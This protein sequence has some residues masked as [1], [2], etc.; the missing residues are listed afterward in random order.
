MPSQSASKPSGDFDGKGFA[1]KLPTR[2]GVYLMRDEEGQALY[3]GKALNLRKRVGS[4]F[5]ARPKGERIMRMV[6]RIRQVE[7][8]ITRTEAEALLLEN[9]WIKSLKPRYNV[10]LRDDKS[11]PWIVLSTDHE[12]P[13]ISF[14]RGARDPKKR[15]FGP[16]PSAHSVRDSIN[17]IQ[18]LF[19]LRNCEDSYFAHRNRP[20]LQHQ[21]RR[22]TAPCVGL[23]NEADYAEQVND[24]VLF[25]CG[26][27]RK[28]TDRLVER[29]ESA[30][31]S[32]DFESAAVYR[33]QINLLQQM[34]A[35][36]FVSGKQ[37]DID[38]IAV[39]SEQG[40]FCVE[41]M[42][43]RGGRHLGQRNFF[44]SQTEGHDRSGVMEAFLGQYYQQRQSP[45]E[46][47]ISDPVETGALL[48][49]VFSEAAG[50]KVRIQPH[51][52]GDRR[53][54][55]EMTRTNARQALLLRLASQANMT[56]QFEDLRDLLG[57]EE[58]PATIECF[59]ISHTAGNETV[60]SC[61][62]FDQNGPVKSKYRRYNLRGITPGDDYAA[63][64]QV[65]S[66][67][68]ARI[69]AEEGSLPDLVLIDGGKG[70]LS[71]AED[72]MGEFGL[73][74]IPIVGIAKGQ[75][76]RAGH[77]QWIT[78]SPHRS[79]FPGPQS[80]ASHLVQQVR[81]E[82]HRFAITG[83]RGRRQKAV[84]KSGLEKI[85]GI[86]PG[87]RRALLNHFG[88]LQGVKQAGIEELSSV[89]GISKVLAETIFR[90]LH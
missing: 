33:D 51:P 75:G 1:R 21:I 24:A 71:Q 57:L 64:H 40:K 29:M 82:A 49:E 20:C 74:G 65:L 12:F 7:V 90:A 68:Y 73:S 47:V 79:L 4:Y 2:P 3:V 72:V 54:M 41:V 16:Y 56:A 45:A 9:E 44:P 55:L 39:A 50:R 85:P 36:Q 62:V 42:S 63:M 14:H 38:F 37:K 8:S 48:A 5:D 67:R 17:L 84:T 89:P 61:V 25:L 15:F 18:K 69:Q 66:R 52:R 10:L 23:V 32:L 46:V 35:Q 83:H 70:Q 76:R 34:Q 87:R 43:I 53:Q 26:R 81:D 28:V 58:A 22:C 80:P 77:E 30:A 88:G 31:T 78:G 60:G 13:R 19:R 59:D 6:A 11:Y 86:G 27:N